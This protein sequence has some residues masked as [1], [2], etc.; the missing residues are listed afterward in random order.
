MLFHFA[1]NATQPSVQPLNHG[2]LKELQNSSRALKE[3]LRI[4]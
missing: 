4:V 1:L 3:L 2:A